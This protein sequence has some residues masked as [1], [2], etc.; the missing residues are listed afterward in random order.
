M[1][2][3]YLGPKAKIE[4]AYE[5][6]QVQGSW[7]IVSDGQDG[8]EEVSKH[9][10]HVCDPKLTPAVLCVCRFA[11]RKRDDS[12][13]SANGHLVASWSRLDS[14][15][16]ECLTTVSR[17]GCSA[18]HH[19]AMTIAAKAVKTGRSL[20]AYSWHWHCATL[21]LPIPLA[22]L[23]SSVTGAS[24]SYATFAPGLIL[25]LVYT[26]LSTERSTRSETA[27]NTT[28]Y[29]Q[30]KRRMSWNS[31][32]GAGHHQGGGGGGGYGPPGGGYGGPPQGQGGWTNAPSPPQYG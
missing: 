25:K 18:M 19:S 3:I 27:R 14:L 10:P 8:R 9:S 7:K 6:S 23:D 29:N 13:R 31:F 11:G 24:C 30:P 22:R 20:C 32:P 16:G 15:R 28:C 26:V 1:Q 5:E 2:T 21:Q 12:R 17:I 4:H